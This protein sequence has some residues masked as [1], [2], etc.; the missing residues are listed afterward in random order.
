[1][2]AE[3]TTLARDAHRRAL[4]ESEVVRSS[5]D[6]ERRAFE[7]ERRELSQHV[8]ST[9][10]RTQVERTLLDTKMEELRADQQKLSSDRA[11]LKLKEELLS[12][13]FD[14]L[15]KQ[16]TQ[17]EVR[18]KEADSK[19]TTLKEKQCVLEEAER[20]LSGREAE[21]NSKWLEITR[22]AKEERE[23]RFQHTSMLTQSHMQLHERQVE[24][25]AQVSEARKLWAEFQRTRMPPAPASSS[26][27][28]GDT[29]FLT[30]PSRS[31]SGSGQGLLGDGSTTVAPLGRK[32]G[33]ESEY[34]LDE[35]EDDA[36]TLVESLNGISLHLGAASRA[37]SVLGG[38]RQ[39]ISLSKTGMSSN[40]Y[41][42]SKAKLRAAAIESG[43]LLGG[44]VVTS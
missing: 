9:E 41:G 24:V 39:S 19:D 21:V 33:G 34:E 4:E 37:K 18:Q 11:A 28:F 1:M 31:H 29:D 17:L 22:I 42:R 20:A 3:A 43:A 6:R 5:L 32:R 30:V 12:P 13:M 2:H 26:Y 25:S 8:A 16:R 23:A 35:E 38:I 10:A 7:A 44:L 15:Q 14:E 27:H 36:K 40:Q